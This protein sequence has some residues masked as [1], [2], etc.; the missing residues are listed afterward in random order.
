MRILVGLLNLETAMPQN[1]ARRRLTDINFEHEGAHCALVGPSV[2]GAAN[3]YTTLV[4]KATDKIEKEFI[5]KATK[6]TV[7]LQFPEFLRKFFGMYW[8]DAEVGVA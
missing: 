3:G 6:V 4:T 8:D 2:G 7:E 1:K 5:D